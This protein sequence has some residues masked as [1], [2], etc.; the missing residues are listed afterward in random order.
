MQ[1]HPWP[2]YFWQMQYLDIHTHHVGV[3]ETYRSILSLSVGADALQLTPGQNVSL[4][5]H[6]WHIQPDFSVQWQGLQQLAR[7]PQVKLIGECGLDKLR[8][9]ALNV[10]EQ[11]FGAQLMLAQEVEKPV[12]I[13]CVKAFDELMAMKNRIKMNVPMVVHGFAK[14][15]QLAAQLNKQGFWLSFGASILNNNSLAATA[16]AQSNRFL[17]ETDNS[18][19]SIAE[20]YRQAAKIKNCTL[21]ELKARIFAHWNEL[22]IL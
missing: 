13:H 14:S 3:T 21:N 11:I 5:I 6:P 17:L 2:S 12:I 8:G 10:Q 16:L 18:R 20:I 15:P 7:H 1:L 4:G 22:N 19:V 9:P